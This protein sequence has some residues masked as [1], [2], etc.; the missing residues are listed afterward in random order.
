MT[1]KRPVGRPKEYDR[2]EIAA[3]MLEWAKLETSINLN[4]FCISLD[5]PISPSRISN[6]AKEKKVKKRKICYC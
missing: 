2:E 5:P 6:W 3:K 1:E 4:G